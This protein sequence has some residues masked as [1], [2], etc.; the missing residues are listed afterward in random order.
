[1]AEICSG[2]EL[3]T[4]GLLGTREIA[5]FE[6]HLVDCIPCQGK[7]ALSQEALASLAPPVPPRSEARNKVLDFSFAP[8]R[9]VDR[10]AYD[11]EA[12]APGV[13]VHVFRDDLARGVRAQ[14]IWTDA[15]AAQ[16]QHLHLG[17]EDILI[18][19]GGLVVD[20][21]EYGEGDICHVQAGWRHAEKNVNGHPC[22]Y[23]VV[24]RTPRRVGQVQ[25][26][27]ER[28]IR[29]AFYP[30]HSAALVAK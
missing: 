3:F 19:E 8:R 7:L 20:D 16:P 30:A 9:P 4:L 6:A 1:M 15:K 13:R 10:G 5:E 23:Y 25:E 21:G 27:P 12:I 24:H 26:A 17:D 18:L 14:L 28:C 29:C 2:I 11:W 22:V